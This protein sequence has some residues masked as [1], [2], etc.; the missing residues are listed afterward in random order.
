MGKPSK[1]RECVLAMDAILPCP[2][3]IKIR[4]GLERAEDKRFAHKLIGKVRLWNAAAS[5]SST[6]GLFQRPA[7]AAI[8]I[9]GRTRQ[10]RY[11]SYADW[12]YISQKCAEAASAHSVWAS[13][14]H[15]WESGYR[16]FSSSTVLTA[17]GMVNEEGAKGVLQR[18][19]ASGCT[20]GGREL[21]E[22]LPLHPPPVPVIGNGDILSWQDWYGH[23]EEGGAAGSSSSSSSSSASGGGGAGGG[24]GGLTTCMLARGALIKPWLPVEIK[25]RRDWDISSRERLD[26]LR[27]FVNFGLEHWGSDAAGVAKT[28]RFL[29]EWLSFLYRYVPVGLLE[30][31]PQLMGDH[32]PAYYGRDDLETLMAS[33]AAED[34]VKISEMLLGP[35]PPGF[36][37]VAKHKSNGAAK[38]EA[39]G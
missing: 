7:V 14:M 10:Q 8:T 22:D 32:A 23:L 6:S 4:T 28:R 36:K 19:A 37:F 2:I 12:A 1:L 13:P 15:L 11:S 20:G 26:I 35:C 39:E 3:T 9:H 21:F 33:N 25:E 30:R 18:S 5:C 16:D 29:L 34:W 17:W 27:D 24:T 38:A 31:L